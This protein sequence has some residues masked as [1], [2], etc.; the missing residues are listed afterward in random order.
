[1]NMQYAEAVVAHE[2]AQGPAPVIQS[3]WPNKPKWRVSKVFLGIQFAI[4]IFLFIPHLHEI[5]EII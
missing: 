4:D 1:M 3:T 2:R 5:M